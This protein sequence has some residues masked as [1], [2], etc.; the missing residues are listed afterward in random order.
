MRSSARSRC[1]QHATGGILYYPFANPPLSFTEWNFALAGESDFST[2]LADVDAFGILGRERVSYATRWTA[3]DPSTPAYNPLKLYR[4]YD[5]NHSTFGTISVSATHDADPGPFSIYAATN[6]AGNSLT[7]M[8]VNKDPV[9]ATQTS[10]M[11]NGFTPSQVKT[12][13]LSQT[14][15]MSIVTGSSQA[16]SSTMTFAPY[17]ATL[18]V[19][20]GST[21]QQ[22]MVEWDLDPDALMVPAGGFGFLLPQFASPSSTTLTLGTPTSDAG[23]SLTVLNASITPTASASI[24]VTAGNTPGFYRFSV[25]ASNNTFQSGWI[26]V[27]KPAATLSATNGDLQ[28]GSVNTALPQPLT[29][30]LAPGQSGGSAGG[31][32][33]L[34]TTSGGVLSNGSV[35][36]RRALVRT[37]TAGAASVTLT[38]P[39]TPGQVGVTAEGPYGLGH[40]LVIFHETAQ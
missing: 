8:I 10:F 37:D 12:H 20:S 4:N 34:F 36:G 3:A 24:K 19:I 7:L 23:I 11:L 35:S 32:S 15:P 40:P 33:I 14:S 29:V 5:G 2:A 16:W 22:P 25:P 28:T 17:S 21:P 31:A 6:S 39:G 27:G 13:S 1:A 26:V 38:L 18:M 9:N 30:T